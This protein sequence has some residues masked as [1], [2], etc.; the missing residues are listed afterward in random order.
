MTLLTDDQYAQLL[1]NGRT[2]AARGA[3][4]QAEWD[5]IPVVKLFTPEPM[6]LGC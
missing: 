5:F 4:D 1:E 3:A 6:P 2:N